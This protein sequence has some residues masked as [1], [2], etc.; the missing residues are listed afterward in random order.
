MK[1]GI[2]G[3]VRKLIE[4]MH[5]ISS[6]SDIGKL[7]LCEK[8]KLPEFAKSP[9]ILHR[10]ILRFDCSQENLLL[11]EESLSQTKTGSPAETAVQPA[12][13]QVFL[14]AQA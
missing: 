14:C 7:P 1:L 10:G 13:F 9:R 6:V 2:R 11:Q 5:S 3:S 4:S 12:G 8:G